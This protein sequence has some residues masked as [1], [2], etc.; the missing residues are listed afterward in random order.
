[1]FN[2]SA[3]S[4]N[5]LSLPSSLT[6]SNATNQYDIRHSDPCGE[7]AAHYV[8]FTVTYRPPHE[9]NSYFDPRRDVSRPCLPISSC[10]V[11]STLNLSTPRCALSVMNRLKTKGTCSMTARHKATTDLS[12]P[13]SSSR[14]ARPKTERRQTYPQTRKLTSALASRAACERSVS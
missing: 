12:Q 7:N 8:H 5:T 3:H 4:S 9:P 13:R 11:N 6:Y 10:K 14:T 2:Q 1:M